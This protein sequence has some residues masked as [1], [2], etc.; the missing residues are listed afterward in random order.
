VYENNPQLRG[1]MDAGYT[2]AHV[3]RPAAWDRWLADLPESKNVEDWRTPE[4][5]A[6]DDRN[7]R[8]TWDPTFENP[9]EI[10][11]APGSPG[12]RPP[13]QLPSTTPDWLKDQESQWLKA[14]KKHSPSTAKQ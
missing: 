11:Y 1:S 8:V 5:K 7:W 2:L 6:D 14:N 12:F 13:V 9:Y 4:Q 3:V 10:Y